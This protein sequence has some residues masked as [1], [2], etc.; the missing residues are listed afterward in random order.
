VRFAPAGANTPPYRDETAKGWGIRFG[1][2]LE[3]GAEGD[4]D[5]GLL[6][7]LVGLG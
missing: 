5:E 7:D 3:S 6:F 1:G 4:V 2:C